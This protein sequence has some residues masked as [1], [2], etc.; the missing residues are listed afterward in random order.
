MVE[1]AGWDPPPVVVDLDNGLVTHRGEVLWPPP[2]QRRKPRR[3]RRSLGPG[4]PFPKGWFGQGLGQ[5]R[6]GIA[7]FECYPAEE[8]PP[9][10]V[11]LNGTFDWLRGAPEQGVSIAG[12]GE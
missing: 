3:D 10:Q 8:L 2:D 1:L 12:D 11:T 4:S 5:F 9:I 7:T 6:A